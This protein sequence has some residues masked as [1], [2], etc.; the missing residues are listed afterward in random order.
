M[1]DVKGRK[2]L[3]RSKMNVGLISMDVVIGMHQV[4][5]YMRVNIAENAKST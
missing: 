1:S 5:I 3:E 2:T 4:L